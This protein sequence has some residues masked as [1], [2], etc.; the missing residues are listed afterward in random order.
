MGMTACITIW[1]NYSLCS[2]NK[3]IEMHVNLES[4]PYAQMKDGIRT[5][6]YKGMI[7]FPA[8]H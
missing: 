4:K 3:E 2:F 1:C 5:R 7:F 8:R 6:H